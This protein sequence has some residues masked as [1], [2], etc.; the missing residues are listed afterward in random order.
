MSW[1]AAAPSFRPISHTLTHTHTHTGNIGQ[2]SIRYF[3]Q[4]GR[5]KLQGDKWRAKK[6]HLSLPPWLPKERK[7]G[8]KRRRIV[9]L[10]SNCTA[11]HLETRKLLKKEREKKVWQSVQKEEASTHSTK[12]TKQQHRAAAASAAATGSSEKPGQ[13]K[14]SRRDECSP[15]QQRQCESEPPNRFLPAS[16]EPKPNRTPS[17]ALAV[18]FQ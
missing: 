6:G 18:H 1:P 10:V 2:I 15:S 14:G 12:R 7:K 13:D 17:V 16:A 8:G 11:L 4:S 3:S 9:S 5:T